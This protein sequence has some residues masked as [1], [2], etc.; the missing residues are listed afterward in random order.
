[1]GRI[2]LA[3]L[4][5]C[6]VA[7]IW[8][9]KVLPWEWIL[10]LG[11]VGGAVIWLG[12]AW[13]IKQLFLAPFRAKGRV[14]RGARADVHAVSPVPAPAP[15]DGEEALPERDWYQVEMTVS[16]T[17]TGGA[18]TLWEPGE[19]R[20][21][22]LTARPIPED[23]DEDDERL[24]VRDLWF[25]REGQPVRDEGEKLAGPVRL[26]LL[27]GVQPGTRQTQLRYYFELFGKVDFPG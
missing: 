6:L 8:G 17:A 5:L 15:G 21:A 19:L 18:F 9:V 27:C 22:R 26:R 25:I 1:M 11:V 24:E 10:V 16:P 14:L 4:A 3:V 13:L 7:F 20:L 23:N 2:I 12:G